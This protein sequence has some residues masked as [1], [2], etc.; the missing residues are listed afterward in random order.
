[1]ERCGERSRARLLLGFREQLGRRR[2]PVAGP[3]HGP[4][5]LPHEDPR[6]IEP[7]EQPRVERVL[8]A[9]D[10]G[11]DRLQLGDDRVLVGR[12]E[13]I[14]SPDRVLLDRGPV[15]SQ[16]LSVEEQARRRA[17]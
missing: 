10:V 3:F 16:L 2:V 7:F 17:S 5:P 6:S 14:P 4:D 1:M 12:G 15:Q 8:G 11:P 9:G 13:G